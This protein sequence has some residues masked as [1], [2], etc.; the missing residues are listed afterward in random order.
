[1]EKYCARDGKRFSYGRIMG[2]K[3]IRVPW[4]RCRAD[5]VDALLFEMEWRKREFSVLAY[6]EEEA[7]EWWSSLA[8][9]ERESQLGEEARTDEEMSLF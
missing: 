9:A 8:E 5:E 2:L 1:M 6:S 3:I 4:I 7:R